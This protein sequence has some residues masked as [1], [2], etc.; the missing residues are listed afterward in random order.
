M[1]KNSKH[2]LTVIFD[3]DGTIADSFLFYFDLLN[4]LAN[5][6]NFNKINPEKIDYYRNLNLHEIIEKLEIPRFRLPFFIFEARK[7][8][9]KSIG[10]IN[11]IIGIKDTLTYLKSMD[12]FLGIITSNS[13]KNVHS[14]LKRNDFTHFDFVFSS[15]RIWDK[16]RSLKK[17]L[18]HHNLDPQSVF[19]VGDETRDIEAAHEAGVKA[20]AVTWGYNSYAILKTYS[21]E[22]IASNQ[23]DLLDIIDQSIKR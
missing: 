22:Y 6:F 1:P 18:H 19:Y 23:Q 21:P 13:V 9:N 8:L 12:I 17:V 16:S 4:E 20:I 14:F 10:Q 15:L 3:F 7:V 2:P 11:P 5:K